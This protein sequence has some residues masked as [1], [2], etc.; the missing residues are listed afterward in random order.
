[1]SERADSPKSKI[2]VFDSGVGGLSILQAIGGR[3][4]QFEYVYASDNAGFPYG[5]KSE[6]ELV[7]RTDKVLRAL[8]RL[9]NP[10]I[11]VIACNTASTVALPKIRSHF[12]KPVVGVV[13]AIKPA[14]AKSTSKVIGLLATPGTVNRAYTHQLISDF[15]SH[16]EVISVGSSEMVELAE[17]KLRGHHIDRDKIAAIVR[18]FFDHPE[19]DTI[20]LACTHF[21]L[22][23]NELLEVASRKVDWIDSGEAIARRVASL[24]GLESSSPVQ[25]GHSFE[26]ILTSERDIDNLRAGLISFGATRLKFLQCL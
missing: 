1:M 16:C 25:A 10:D 18:P 14:A 15:A 2:L 13:P 9:E 6:V 8:I 12:T 17:Q 20:V 22:L 11:V 5:T 7:E 3:L 4:P 24:L 19:L 21:P 26:A 23:Q